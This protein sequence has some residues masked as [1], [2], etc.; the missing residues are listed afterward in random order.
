L[1]HCDTLRRD[2]PAF[3]CQR[4]GG[5]G[6]TDGYGPGTSRRGPGGVNADGVTAGR[7]E[8]E[9]DMTLTANRPAARRR[10]GRQTP[11]GYRNRSPRT[12]TGTGSGCGAGSRRPASGT[13]DRLR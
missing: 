9:E 3:T 10:A 11:S 12:G 7:S 8:Y 4:P 5:P 1:F 13:G 2:R 6:G